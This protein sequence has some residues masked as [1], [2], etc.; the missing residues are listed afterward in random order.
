MLSVATVWLGW[1]GPAWIGNEDPG[2][3]GRGEGGAVWYGKAGPV[4]RGVVRFS[5]VMRCEA[6]QALSCLVRFGWCLV[7]QAWPGAAWLDAAW[8][9]VARQGL[10]GTFRWDEA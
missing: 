2:G 4:W 5:A 6:R 9:G 10:A 3:H 7:R 1:P 8:L